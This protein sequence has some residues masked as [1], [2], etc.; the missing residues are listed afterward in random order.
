[1]LTTTPDYNADFLLEHRAIWETITP[2]S[3]AQKDQP[4][5]KV[6]LYGIPIAEFNNGPSSI[7]LIKEE[8]T[9]FN[10]GYTPIGN[11]YWLTSADKRAT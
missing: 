7:D 5:Y 3:L 8:I 10:K 6:V 11:P 1:M 2:F 4:W 9:T